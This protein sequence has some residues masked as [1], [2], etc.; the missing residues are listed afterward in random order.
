M[1]IIK[2]RPKTLWCGI[3]GE[4]P[5]LNNGC[6]EL[7]CGCGC[8]L[9]KPT[10]KVWITVDHASQPGPTEMAFD[11]NR[12]AFRT[13]SNNFARDMA[14]YGEAFLA[15]DPAVPTIPDN[16][17][18]PLGLGRPPAP[19]V[20]VSEQQVNPTTIQLEALREYIRQNPS[21]DPSVP[22]NIPNDM[23]GP[24]GFDSPALTPSYILNNQLARFER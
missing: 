15:I 7:T 21:D 20:Y 12:E 3:C 19:D 10:H 11:Q 22:P 24:L 18:G 17:V 13:M 8:C 1:R 23:L 6:M 5:V 4:R 2:H 14:I 16:M 9:I